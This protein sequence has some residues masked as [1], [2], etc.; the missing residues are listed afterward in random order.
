MNEEIIKEKLLLLFNSN[1]F[2]CF[3]IKKNHSLSKNLFV[4]VNLF[5]Y[6]LLVNTNK[7]FLEIRNEKSKKFNFNQEIILENST[8]I[9]KKDLIQY[10]YNVF[11]KYILN[12]NDTQIKS[13]YTDDYDIVNE[14]MFYRI[15]LY[16]HGWNI[17]QIE[18]YIC[19]KYNINIDNIEID[20]HIYTTSYN[21][22]C[23]I[24]NI[25]V[26]KLKKNKSRGRPT[27]PVSLKEYNKNK[28]KQKMK[29]IMK[30]KYINLSKLQSNLLT[31][32]EF[33]Y[34]K[35]NLS[36]NNNIYS[37]ILEKLSNLTDI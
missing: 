8:N 36:N 1:L 31:N 29:I 10:F 20:E 16:L 32:D 3:H 19:K 9:L 7:S 13:K 21:N 35:N 23:F 28:N 33:N 34:I 37:T 2:K 17:Y 6:D 26:N 27:L 25:K 30:D 5:K 24:K 4:D 14:R 11:C 18:K 12:F 22:I 15:E